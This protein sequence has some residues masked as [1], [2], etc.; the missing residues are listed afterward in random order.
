MNYQE[1]FNKAYIGLASRGFERSMINGIIGRCLY[2]GFNGKKCAI[3]HCIPDE[4]Y[5]P[6]M[7]KPASN[8]FLADILRSIGFIYPNQ[9]DHGGYRKRLDFAIALQ[10][11]HDKSKTPDAMKRRL[12]ELATEHSLTIPFKIGVDNAGH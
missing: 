11:C 7:D 6:E 12:H 1:M 3:G 4:L 9:S 10:S 2:R 5:D 8:T